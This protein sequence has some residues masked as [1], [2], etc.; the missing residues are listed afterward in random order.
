MAVNSTTSA[1]TAATPATTPT[2]ASL[3]ASTAPS[4]ASETEDRFLT[5][6]VAQMQNQDPLNPV[7]NAQ[8]TTQMAQIQTVTGLDTINKTVAGLNAQFAQLQALSGA[9]LVG[10]GVLVDG[11]QMQVEDGAGR[12]GFELLTPAD[13]VKLE[14]LDSAGRVI[15]TETLGAMPTGRHGFNWTPPSGVNAEQAATFRV[16][17]TLGTAA[18]SNIPLKH[19]R[20]AAVAQ[21][22]DGLTLELANGG[23]YS[24]EQ[25]RVFD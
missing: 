1:G 2:A 11:N 17:A 10:R 9:S 24:Y 14:V 15:D 6:L 21:G 5:L 8:V 20:I 19:D 4:S 18:V 16:T 23:L 12:A 7:D 25:I 13:Q 3:L 22:A